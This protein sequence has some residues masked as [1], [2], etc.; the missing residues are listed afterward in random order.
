MAGN[1]THPVQSSSVTGLRRKKL[2]SDESKDGIGATLLQ[3]TDG[4]WMPVAYGSCAKTSAESN[5]AQIEKEQLGVAFACERF[6]SYIYG[7][8]TNIETDHLPLIAISKKLLCDA[9]PRLQRLLLRLQKYNSTLSYPPGKHMVIADT[10]SRAFSPRE[11]P[12]KTEE[13]MQIH[14]CAVK[15]VLSVSKR[16]WKEIAEETEKDE[17]LKQAIRSIDDDPK[18][19][20]KLYATFVEDL[21]VVDCVLLKGQRIVIRT[22]MRPEMRSLAHEGHLGIEKCK[23]RAREVMYWPNMNNDV[24]DFVSRCDICQKHRYAQQ[25]QPLQSHERQ[26]RP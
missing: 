21:T 17:V 2:S 18:A 12:S 20:P 3:E 23:R 1:Q 11:V 25:Q 24:C 5:Y 16:K 9:Q 4:Q 26:D 6:H 8:T 22:K 13:D 19:C 10:L 14:V 7:R 15:A